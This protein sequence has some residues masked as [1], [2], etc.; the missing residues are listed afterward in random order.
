MKP[1]LKLFAA[2]LALFVIVVPFLFAEEAA[3]SA[4]TASNST[5][6][7]PL[8]RILVAKGVI[9]ADEARFIGAGNNQHEKLLFLLK[10]KG[11]L[12]TSD[13][14]QLVPVTASQTAIYQPAVLTTV[15]TAPAEQKLAESKPAAP[16]VIPAVA[17]LRVLQVDPPKKDGLIPDIKLGSGAR[18]KFYGFLK[19]SVVHDSSSP[20]G[21]DFPLPGFIGSIDTGPNT[22]SEFH[23]KARATRVGANFEWPDI[24]PNLTFAGKIE[25]DFEGNFTR[26]ANRN[27]SSIRSSSPS[28]RLAYGR[29]DYRAS[30][31]TTYFALFGQDWTPFASSTLPNIL[32]TTGFGI[33]YGV[34]WERDPQVRVGVQHNFGGSRKFTIGP[35]FA[36]VLPSS[37][38]PPASVNAATT[39]GAAF[40]GMDNQLAYGERQGPDSGRPQIQGRLVL[41]WQLD[42]APGVAPAQLI[43]SGMNGSRKMLVPFSQFNTAPTTPL[44]AGQAATLAMV[45]SQYPTGVSTGSNQKGATVEVQLPTR[46]VTLLAKYY[47][48]EDLRYYFAGGLYSVFNNTAGLANTISV[49]SMDGNTII[50]GTN[51]AGKAMVAPQQPVRVQGGFINLGFPIGRLIHA[52]P[53]SRV[54]GWQFYL[55]YG[56]DDPYS[57][58]VRRTGAISATSA[59][60]RDK[61]DMAAATM[62]W[63]ANSLITFGWEE[64]YYRTRLSNGSTPTI[65]AP[66][67]DGG[68]V[69]SW[70]DVRNEFSTIFSF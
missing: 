39:F 69:R 28:I 14:D 19:T 57:R 46:W 4:E 30:E 49:A 38:N 29:V 31:N 65:T 18:L 53:T 1:N 51:A 41:Q 42:K 10:E 9:T 3:K 20:Y 11:V 16:K 36:L 23:L 66:T 26:V 2:L 32:E 50:L 61:S 44:T 64:S 43:F 70:H 17:P 35:E 5:A 6:Q 63:K 62:Y 7:E 60:L 25:F 13:L 15:A 33:G 45:K 47:T 48:G 21:N 8:I 55:H 12:S 59:G 67:W 56:L 22:G 68:P 52:E 24:S 37:G 27:I 40:A 54:A 34:L 58:D